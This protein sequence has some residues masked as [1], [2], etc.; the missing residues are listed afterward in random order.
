[1][2]AR[3]YV[4]LP[5]RHP[6]WIHD[7]YKLVRRLNPVTGNPLPVKL[8]KTA[9]EVLLTTDVTDSWRFDVDNVEGYSLLKDIMNKGGIVAIA[10]NYLEGQAPAPSASPFTAIV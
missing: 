10:G 2:N 8:P 1:M 7:P 3:V 4:Q 6:G 9:E 5:K